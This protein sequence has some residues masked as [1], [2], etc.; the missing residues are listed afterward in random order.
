LQSDMVGVLLRFRLYSIA[1]QADIMKMFLQIGLKE[2]DRDVTRF[3]WKDLSKDKLH[4]YRFNRVCFGLTCSPFLAMAVIRHHAELKKEVYPEAARIVEN[5][6]YVDD[7]LLS[8]ENQEAARRMIK[9]LDSLMES[10][11]FKLAKWASNDSSVLSDIAVEKRATTDNREIL[12]TLGLHWNRDRDEFTFCER[13]YCSKNYGKPAWIGMNP[14]PAV[15]LKT[16]WSKWK[17]KAKNLWKIK[18]PSCLILPPVEETNS[19]ELHVYGDAS[20]WAYGAVA[21]LKVISK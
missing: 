18:I 21:Y 3:L 20:K 17:R 11:G 10:G 9:D 16:G 1:V 4:V 2:K 14:L 13:K 6:I 19:I 8:V 15:S 12:R 7:V 5:N